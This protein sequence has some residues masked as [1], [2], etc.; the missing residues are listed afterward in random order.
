MQPRIF[1]SY[2]RSDSASAAGRLYDTLL[3]RL[4]RISLFK[5]I[6]SILIGQN[7]EEEIVKAISGCSAFILVIGK[8]FNNERR[9]QKSNNYVRVEIETALRYQKPVIPVFVDG[10]TMPESVDLPESIQTISKINGA[11][12]RNE[13]WGSDFDHLYV[14]MER[15]FFYEQKRM[16]KAF[17]IELEDESK[18]TFTDKREET[19]Y[20][21]ARVG[22]L[23]WFTENLRYQ[24]SNDPKAFPG[25]V[26]FYSNYQKSALPE[27][28]RLPGKEDFAS[29]I[30][31]HKDV[32]EKL[33][34]HTEGFISPE[35][36]IKNQG[37]NGYFWSSSPY[38]EKG[39]FWYLLYSK[40]DQG[41][42]L[43]IAKGK[44]GMN[45]RCVLD[46][47]NLS[48]LLMNMQNDS[49]I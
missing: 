5:D 36:G 15:V 32:R 39:W 8:N 10:G 30:A 40:I 28:W 48:D 19:G 2:Q 25:Y 6:D 3:T 33:L 16:L 41:M 47:S 26:G 27:G 37:D 34:L 46:D 29:L 24:G 49:T 7:F 21:I 31:T 14:E 9:L 45:I 17:G 23:W 18:G 43:G 1:I 42:R 44:Y 12:L 4:G 38:D 20:S 13:S 11:F 35:A 22:D